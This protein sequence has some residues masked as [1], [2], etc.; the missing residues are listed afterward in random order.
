MPATTPLK[1]VT[2]Q[3]TFCVVDSE[4]LATR[5]ARGPEVKVYRHWTAS[6]RIPTSADARCCPALP[7]RSAN[8]FIQ[9]AITLLPE[10]HR[11]YDFREA[12]PEA[13]LSIQWTV[14]GGKRQI[15]RSVVR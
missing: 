9:E 5:W 14:S 3:I 1:S 4:A 15:K 12:I 11:M 13:V 8:D 10:H 2:T 6:A 7:V